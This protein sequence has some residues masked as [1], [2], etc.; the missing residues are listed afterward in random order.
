M[1]TRLSCI[2]ALL[3]VFATGT[4]YAKFFND[5]NNSHWAYSVISKMSD[6]GI[7]SGYPD[8]SFA[9]D[10][11]ISRVEFL[12]ILAVSLDLDVPSSIKFKDVPD[13]HWARKYIDLAGRYLNYYLDRGDLLFK[14]D[15]KALREDVTMALVQALGLSNETYSTKTLD[16]FTDKSQISKAR[17][18]F[19]AIA[20]EKNLVKGNA[21][22]TFN[23][24]G[25]LTRAQVCQLMANA[26]EYMEESA[27]T[28]SKHDDCE[29]VWSAWFPSSDKMH[30]RYCLLNPTHTQEKEHV[31]VYGYCSECNYNPA[32]GKG[33][34]PEATVVPTPV[35]T[36]E[37]QREAKTYRFHYY[38]LTSTQKD[39]YDRIVK[40]CSEFEQ[41]V[42]LN[43]NLI[44]DVQLARTAVFLDYP[45]FYWIG[46]FWYYYDRYGKIAKL[47]F[48]V[49]DNVKSTLN[50][51]NNKVDSI[52]KS[53]S[54]SDAD[55][56][57]EI[58]EWIANNTSYEKTSNDQNI[59][60]VLIEGKGVCA[61][62][63]KTFKYICD[64]LGIESAVI[65]G[66]L[67]ENPD[68][69]EG[70]SK[71]I[72]HEWNVVK[73]N[74]EYYWVDVTWGDTYYTAVDKTVHNYINYSYCLVSDKE[75]YAD[76][77]QDYYSRYID[78]TKIE[79]NMSY[80]T[81]TDESLNYFRING[82]YFDDYDKDKIGEY[83]GSEIQKGNYDGI[84]AK[85]GEDA[86]FNCFVQD[87]LKNGAADTY[88][89]KATGG[90]S[91]Y[92]TWEYFYKDKIH[93]I[94][95]IFNRK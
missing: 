3:V 45:Q 83:I 23:P 89:K 41:F 91:N 40:G 48:D 55:K 65:P 6:S 42:D 18:K 68:E 35:P 93:Y 49:P 67:Y 51:M 22:G 10:K 2:I 60:S 36:Q 1:K 20:V 78:G 43:Y 72:F 95:I 74:G 46:T 25:M 59:T 44:N 87:F 27:K 13:D 56:I 53:L 5:V 52:I 58:Y 8:G 15:D 7:V 39:I 90:T 69:M 31:M 66:S 86:E 73:L 61:G 80:P 17:E 92:N 79:N 71:D 70:D 76:H 30:R 14:P 82:N 63:S 77:Y 11:S 54:G 64:K 84:E 81:C 88:A 29:H 21:D 38:N 94:R 16:N 37:P 26:L 33:P 12:K 57:R 28:K 85:F 34:K 47:E 50:T 62:Y 75:I 32:I 4:C 24:K 9:P 19:I